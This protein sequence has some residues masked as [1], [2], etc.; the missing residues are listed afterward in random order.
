L[1]NE[2]SGDNPVALHLVSL[3]GDGAGRSRAM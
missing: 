2:L 3:D 1:R